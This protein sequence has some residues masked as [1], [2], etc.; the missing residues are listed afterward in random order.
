[1]IFICNFSILPLILISQTGYTQNNYQ[2]E[3]IQVDN[4]VEVL[5][6][7]S[8]IYTSNTLDNNPNIEGG[9]EVNLRPYLTNNRDEV[10]VKLYNGHEPYNKDEDDKHWEIEYSLWLNQTEYDLMWNEG[11]DNRTGLVSEEKYYL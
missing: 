1:M 6:N 2:L 8:L 3:F 5:V 10:I 7:D 9:L 11:D 4:K